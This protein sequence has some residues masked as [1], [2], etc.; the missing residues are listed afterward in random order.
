MT[1]KERTEKEKMLSNEWYLS[2]DKEL[3][4]DRNNCQALL[5]KLNSLPFGPERNTVTQELFDSIGQDTFINRP[6]TCDYGYNISFGKQC[7]L[8][9]NCVFLDIGKVK[10]GDNV[11]MGP[12]VHIYTVNH[13]LDP[14]IRK[15]YY[16]IGKDV[17][18][19]DDVW[20]GGGA[21]ILPGV[22]IGKG[23]T[24]GA[25]AVVTKSMPPYVLAAG[26][27]CKVIKSIEPGQ[28]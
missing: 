1:G 26:N 3:V 17:V 9:Y 8:N 16:E 27:P 15:Q 4:E 24:I 11:F 12:G 6:F 28:K 14:A 5:S 2:Y 10:I 21:I 19:K 20:I 23:T 25:G 7:E 22:T 18:I 13:P